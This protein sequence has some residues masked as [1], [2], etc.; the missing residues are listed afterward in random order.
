MENKVA[1]KINEVMYNVQLDFDDVI[2]Q[3]HVHQLRFI[4]NTMIFMKAFV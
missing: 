3:R 1:K 4:V 2:M